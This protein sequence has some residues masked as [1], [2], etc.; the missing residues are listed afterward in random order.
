MTFV[1]AG[2]SIDLADVF[3]GRFD[4]SIFNP[5]ALAASAV[6]FVGSLAFSRWL[7]QREARREGPP[8]HAA[9]GA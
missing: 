8:E 4:A 9:P 1:L 3:A 2:A 7:K 5:W 6:L